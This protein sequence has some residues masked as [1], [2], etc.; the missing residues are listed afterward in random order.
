MVAKKSPRRK[1]S[2]RN[3][4]RAITPADARALGV[5]F[6]R[7]AADAE[8]RERIELGLEDRTTATEYADLID[9][10]AWWE[11]GESGH[12]ATWAI[13]NRP[14]LHRAFTAGARSAAKRAAPPNSTTRS[15]VSAKSANALGASIG[16]E[17][18]RQ[19]ARA[20]SVGDVEMDSRVSRD[21]RT[22]LDVMLE[23][24]VRSSLAYVDAETDRAFSA[25]RT[26]SALRA[27][28]ARGVR[29]AARPVLRKFISDG[30]ASMRTFLASTRAAAKAPVRRSAKRRNPSLSASE[31]REYLRAELREWGTSR[32]DM[33]VGLWT[34]IAK[35]AKVSASE[36]R[37][38]ADVAKTAAYTARHGQPRPK[39]AMEMR[40]EIAD[41]LVEQ[42]DRASDAAILSYAKA[43]SKFI[44]K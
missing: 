30:R 44:A 39:A 14:P 7:A 40:R 28:F 1:P 43:R 17:A 41:V 21:R 29:S 3:P 24:V 37:A 22:V 15:A 26:G 35:A 25:A 31:A 27:A 20:T 23:D 6:G 33:P 38:V 10:L 12:P 13:T 11:F 4:D 34:P 19:F 42:V 8:R 5:K 36:M 32:E 16:A 9:E 18:A 2:Q